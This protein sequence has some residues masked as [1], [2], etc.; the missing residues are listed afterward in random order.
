[1]HAIGRSWSY[2]PR[3]VSA[4]PWATKPLQTPQR[5]HMQVSRDVCTQGLGSRSWT[6]QRGNARLEHDGGKTA[7]GKN[8]SRG[9]VCAMAARFLGPQR[10][11]MTNTAML[12]RRVNLATQ[13]VPVL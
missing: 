7:N 13:S 2:R 10:I 11:A 1:M 9:A 3:D 8:S 4:G 5:R 12:K 6:Q